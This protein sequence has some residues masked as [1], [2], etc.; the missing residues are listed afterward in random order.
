M[1]GSIETVKTLV[2][3]GADVTLKDNQGSTAEDH[4]EKNDHME[5]VELLKKNE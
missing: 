4:A 5:I 1:T 2:D 3:H